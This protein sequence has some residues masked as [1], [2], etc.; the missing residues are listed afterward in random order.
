MYCFHPRKI[1][2]PKKLDNKSIFL[3][4][5]LY[6][7]CFVNKVTLLLT[8]SWAGQLAS[9]S[10]S[11]IVLTAQLQVSK[12]VNLLTEHPV[13]KLIRKNGTKKVG[14]IRKHKL[15]K[16]A[17]AKGF[18]ILITNFCQDWEGECTIFP[19]VVPS[20]MRFWCIKEW[21]NEM[22]NGIFPYN[23]T[24][25]FAFSYSSCLVVHQFFHTQ[26]NLAITKR[27]VL[28]SVQSYTVFHAVAIFQ[29]KWRGFSY[30]K[31]IT[32]E[33]C[34]L[35]T[36]AHELQLLLRSTPSNLKSSTNSLLLCDFLNYETKLH[37]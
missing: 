21:E 16:S 1:G 12:T 32:V 26:F 5:S 36:S 10:V 17:D 27:C 30:T 35:L 2:K 14:I 7:G 37:H 24:Y 33:A 13:W 20:Q 6:T 11:I 19:Y 28:L 31:R 22:K 8:Y 9:A 4:C 3:Q 25:F 18:L 34:D 23:T 15:L 29:E